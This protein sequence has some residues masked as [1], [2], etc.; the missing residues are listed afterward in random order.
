MNNALQKER[1]EKILSYQQEPEDTVTGAKA[2]NKGKEE[3]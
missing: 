1:R 2:Q 3:N